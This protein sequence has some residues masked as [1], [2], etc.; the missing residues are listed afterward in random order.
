MWTLLRE[1]RIR[2]IWLG[3]TINA[4]GSGLSFWAIAWLLYRRYPDAPWVAAS[5]LAAQGLG[6]M[7]GTV[8]LGAYLD[9]W[10]RRRVLV[11]VN[12]ALAGLTAL[13][14]I[15][16]QSSSSPAILACVGFVLGVAGSLPQPALSASLPSFVP[17]ERLQALQTLL[18]LTW[19]SAGLIAPGLAG[20]LIAAIGAGR[21]LW[22]DAA[23]FLAAVIAY[24]LV[25]FPPQPEPETSS[26]GFGAWWAQVRVG[27]GFFASRPALWGTMIGV[28]SVNGL[29]EAFNG[30]FL[31][32]VS[33]RL[34]S[35]VRLPA[36]LGSD[37]GALGLGLFDTVV[38]VFE[39]LGSVWL[40]SQKSVSSLRVGLRLVL[41]GCT[42]PMLGML[43][44]VLAPNLGVAI[45]GCVVQGACISLVSSVWPGV[46]ARLVPEG[47]R[48]RVSSVRFFIGNTAR[49]VVTALSGGLLGRLGV[50][51][52]GVGIT[53]AFVGLALLG[54][55]WAARDQN[56]E[57]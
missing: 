37:V 31:P 17:V 27:F 28:S 21:V 5:V 41:L 18:N 19:L 9:H 33:D 16:I 49:P 24:S 38:V 44:V 43:V 26:A 14:V 8:G 32:R 15:V 6:T 13:V 54:H 53:L 48:G 51:V 36:W 52:L 11:A 7:L 42:G 40:G 30:L 4:L 56:L 34:L 47:L 3:E 57:R 22:L 23:S 20:L 2:I 10:D 39:L 55:V 45:L 12:L 50:R 46:F 29:F 1:H 35:G 25:R